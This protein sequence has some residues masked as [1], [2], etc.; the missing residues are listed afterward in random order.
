MTEDRFHFMESFGSHQYVVCPNCEECALFMDG[1]LTCGSCGK[2]KKA[3]F[4]RFRGRASLNL[5][6]KFS[7]Y[8]A[9]HDF[10][11]W[12]KVEFQGEE[13]WAVNE[14]HLLFLQDFISQKLRPSGSERGKYWNLSL[15]SRLPKWI[16]DGKNAI[17]C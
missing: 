9:G 8:H 16:K 11:L 15:E 3:E 12:L 14:E 5:A 2:F 6:R 10:K 4:E 17:N 1:S 7:R 13:L